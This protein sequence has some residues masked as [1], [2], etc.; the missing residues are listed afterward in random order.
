MTTGLSFIGLADW[1]PSTKK[2]SCLLQN[3]TAKVSQYIQHFADV[4]DSSHHVYDLAWDELRR[5]YGQP[6]IIA[7]ACQEKLL[8]FPK[9]ERDVA[10]SLNKLNILEK[11]I[12]LPWVIK[13]SL[14]V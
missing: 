3:C 9:I 2:L 13:M 6:Y 11:R 8:S 1:L 12:V 14:R 4:H 7:Q 5:R 10:E